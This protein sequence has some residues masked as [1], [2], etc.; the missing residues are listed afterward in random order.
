[1]GAKMRSIRAIFHKIRFPWR[2]DH[3][4]TLRATAMGI[5]SALIFGLGQP[6]FGASPCGCWIDVKTG[7]QVPSVPRAG[8]NM[9]A[10]A[11][12]DAGVAVVGGGGKTAFNSRNG[13]NYA[14]DADGCWI[15]VKTGKQVPSVPRA[16]INMFA[17]AGEDAGVAVIGEGGKT[18]FNPRNG[19]NYAL[20]PCPPP[21]TA[22]GPTIE[23]N[24]GFGDRRRTDDDEDTLFGGGR[25]RPCSGIGIGG[26]GMGGCAEDD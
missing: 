13:K 2:Y 4:A 15:D 14:L 9:F 8:V 26:F 19:K 22:G 23:L 16:G 18:A 5:L 21:R 11:G 1:M 12:E 6:A 7:K 17:G 3:I 10:G 24:L 25:D 20:E